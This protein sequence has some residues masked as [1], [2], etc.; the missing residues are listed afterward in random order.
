MLC[1]VCVNGVGQLV[2]GCVYG[3]GVVVVDFFEDF[4]VYEFVINLLGC[5]VYCILNVVWEFQNFNVIGFQMFK[6]CIVVVQVLRQ[7]LYVCVICGYFV[8]CLL[9]WCQVFE[10][11]V[12]YCN[13]QICCWFVEVCSVVEFGDF[14][15]ISFFVC[16]RIDLF[17][18]V[19]CVGC[20][21]LVY[22]S[23]WKVLNGCVYV[24]Q[25]FIV[26][27]RYMEFQIVEV[28]WVSDFFVE[29]VICLCICVICQEGFQIKDFIQFVMQSVVVVVVVLVVEFGCGYVERYVGEECKVWVLVDEV[30]VCC[31]I[32]VS[33]I[34]SYCVKYFECV[35]EFVC[36]FYF[37]GQ[38]IVGDSCDVFC[39]FNCCVKNICEVMVLRCY[40]SQGVFVLS[41]RLVLLVWMLLLQSYLVQMFLEKNDDLQNVFFDFYE[42]C[43]NN[44][45]CGGFQCV[46]FRCSGG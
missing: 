30:V 43:I 22:F 20:Q 27:V 14:L 45:C 26:E 28:F 40:Y 19:D 3:C 32:Y 17:G 11:F 21:C 38:L 12:V 37:D 41:Y 5:G 24:I 36:C 35:N 29:L 16:L 6:C 13:G 18:I 34:C 10:Y 31:V 2:R 7:V 44:L 8:C 42:L 39:S 4:V 1:V 46:E 33:L 9:R 23:I 15:E 25:C